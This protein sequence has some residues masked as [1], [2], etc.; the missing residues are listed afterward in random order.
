MAGTIVANTI[1]TDTAGA[2]FTTNNALTGVAKAWVRFSVSGTTV[3][4]NGS[5]NMSSVTR[6]STGNYTFALTTAMPNANYSVVPA[7][8]GIDVAGGQY[9]ASI[10]FGIAASPFYALPTTTTFNVAYTAANLSTRADPLTTSVAVF[11]S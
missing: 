2:V 4:I 9:T 5:F 7:M 1:N 10:P 11:S 8:G 6:D 3:T